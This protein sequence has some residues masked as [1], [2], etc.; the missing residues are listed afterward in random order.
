MAKA[1]IKRIK[2]FNAGTVRFDVLET[3]E[4]LEATFDSLSPEIQ[5]NLGIHGMN[6][7]VAGAASDPK[8]SPLAAMTKMWEN[9]LAGIWSVKGDG[10]A[11]ITDLVAALMEF[12]GNTQPEVE[13]KL[14]AMKVAD[15]AN[16]TKDVASLKKHPDLAPILER[17]KTERQKDREKEA[18]AAKKENETPLTF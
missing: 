10:V 13:E 4:Y 6:D 12:S 7:R 2:D 14:D 18:K 1:R 8:V 15:E 9:L 11:K 3:G 17:M 16:G 5:R